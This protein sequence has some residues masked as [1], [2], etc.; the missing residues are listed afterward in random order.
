MFELTLET[1]LVTDINDPSKQGKIQINIESKFKKI[2]K[3]LLPWAIPLISNVSEST[4]SMNLPSVGSQVW[5]LRDTFW[6]R[7]YYISNRYFYNLFDFSKVKGLL[8]KCDKINKEYSKIRFEYFEDGSLIF[9]NNSDGSSG[10]ITKQG[11]II[12]IDNEGNL[13]KSIN[14]DEIT[15]IKGNREINIKGKDTFSVNGNSEYSI[16]GKDIR[17]VTSNLEYKANGS[18]TLKSNTVQLVEIGNTVSTLGQILNEIC[19]DLS[20]LVTVGNDKTQTSPTL[21]AQMSALLPRIKM[22]FK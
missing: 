20:T 13:V 3:D 19:T 18:V 2:Q 9:H 5:I 6:K 21:S 8:D 22:T 14:K 17:N 11:T 16:K 1:A 15:E 4:M 10:I 12:F 7:F